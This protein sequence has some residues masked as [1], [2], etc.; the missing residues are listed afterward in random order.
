[1]VRYAGGQQ[2]Q[3]AGGISHPLKVKLEEHKKARTKREV[4]KS[5][6]MGEGHTLL[7]LG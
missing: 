1:M 4:E 7:S 5:A 3:G 6:L 2:W